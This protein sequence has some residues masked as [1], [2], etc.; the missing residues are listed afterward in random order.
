M[1]M[2]SWTAYFGNFIVVTNTR[3]ST[4]KIQEVT[5]IDPSILIR[6]NVYKKIYLVENL[7]FKNVCILIKLPFQLIFVF[8]YPQMVLQCIQMVQLHLL[9]L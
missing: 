5:V 6:L 9:F 2:G 8:H 7:L 1:S 4:N 3:Y